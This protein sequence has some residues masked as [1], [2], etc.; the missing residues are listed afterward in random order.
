V[1]PPPTAWPLENAVLYSFIWM[2]L[3]LVV[4]VPLTIQQ[5]KRAVS[6]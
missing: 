6:R 4:F 3:L 1:V 2:A 5:Y